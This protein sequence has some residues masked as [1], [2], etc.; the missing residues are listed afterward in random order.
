M[1]ISLL[2]ILSFFIF[3]TAQSQYY[4]PPV[5][6]DDWETTSPGEL[7]WCADAIDSLYQFLEEKNTK[8]F[9][10]LKDGKIVLEEYFNGHTQDSVW[11]WASAGKTLTAFL[12]GM[13]QQEGDLS[14][15]DKTS[16]YLGEGWTSCTPE[17]ENL[18]TI[19]HQLTM[20][21]GMDDWQPD[22]LDPECLLYV[23][24]AGTRWAYHNASYRLLWQVTEAATGT[25]YNTYTF[26]KLLQPTGMTGIWLLT[27]EQTLFL[28][29]A[30]SMARFGSLMLNEGS[31]DGNQIMTDSDYFED[32]IT[33]SQDM[34]ESYGYLWWL[35]GQDSHMLPGF[36]IVWPGML[37]PNGPADMYSGLG[38]NGQFLDVVP[39]ENLVV[40][41]MGEAPD[42]SFVAKAFHNDMWEKLSAVMCTPTA[43]EDVASPKPE[44]GV[45]PNPFRNNLRIS[46]LKEGQSYQ[47]FDAMGNMVAEDDSPLLPTRDLPSGVYFLRVFENEA[48]IL[49]ERLVRR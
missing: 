29:R 14:I 32:M 20:T 11:Y 35:N 48:V 38:K 18:I 17:Q 23:A 46:G 8:A 4:F 47:L 15:D 25:N 10:V 43:S 31:W 13:A 42:N 45:M 1:K 24:D 40:V 5:D 3:Q 49:T 6:S 27:P 9:I 22:C 28:S 7:G 37:E 30:R 26:Q 36:Q 41:R 21:S 19:W 33:P 16:E 44:I 39:S 2:A 34:N 12:V